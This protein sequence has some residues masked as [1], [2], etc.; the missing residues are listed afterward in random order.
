MVLSVLTNILWKKPDGPKGGI[1]AEEMGLGKTIISLALVLLNPSTT[2]EHV[3]P[4]GGSLPGQGRHQDKSYSRSVP[5]ICS[6][7][8]VRRGHGQN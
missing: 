5:R 7:T 4:A 2:Y 6:V 1:L 3:G 8:M